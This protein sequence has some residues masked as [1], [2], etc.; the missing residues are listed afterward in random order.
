MPNIKRKQISNNVHS[1]HI[2]P[3]MN[4]LKQTPRFKQIENY[5]TKPCSAR[6]NNNNDVR[7]NECNV[8]N[9][10]KAMTPNKIILPKINKRKYKINNTTNHTSPHTNINDNTNSIHHIINNI[11]ELASNHLHKK[12][13]LQHGDGSYHSHHNI[14]HSNNNKG[15][16][17]IIPIN[18]NVKHNININESLIYQI[19]PPSEC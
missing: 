4:L 5:N 16:N 14:F 3:S 19:K 15:N 7:F 8:N 11:H 13:Q 10:N 9:N 12:K 1:E 17:N 18:N 6:H 2:I